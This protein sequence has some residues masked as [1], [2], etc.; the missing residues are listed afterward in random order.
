MSKIFFISDI[1]GN[2]EALKAVFEDI[3]SKGG[4]QI[5][6]LGDSVGYYN[7]FNQV[8]DLLKTN[9]VISL[10]GNHDYALLKTKGVI[11][12]S[13]TCTAILKRQLLE[14]SEPNRKYLESCSDSL[15]IEFHGK[16]IFCVH[17]GLEDLRNEYLWDVSK[18]Y[19]NRNNFKYDFLITGHTHHPI[20]KKI[21]KYMHLNPGSV[22]Q[23]R[24][25]DNRASYMC[26]SDDQIIIERVNYSFELTIKSMKEDGY[27]SYISDVLRSGSKIT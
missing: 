1:H 20:K 4:G 11:K 26:I 17:G 8:L 21:G 22:G 25:W 24:D 16:K 3:H 9:N 10:I 15:I 13:K 18:E 7:Q 27:G 12:T 14:I 5:Y 6:C 23:P 2:I 19:L